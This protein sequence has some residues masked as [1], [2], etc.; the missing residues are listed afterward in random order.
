MP[1]AA[2]V[3]VEAPLAEAAK[4]VV[5]EVLEAVAPEVLE[6]KPLVNLKKKKLSPR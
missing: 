1:V 6:A 5:A 3:K 2:E 4:K